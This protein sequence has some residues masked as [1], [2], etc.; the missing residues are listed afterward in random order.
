MIQRHFIIFIHLFIFHLIQWHLTRQGK[1]SAKFAVIFQV[2]WEERESSV[3]T[4]SDPKHSISEQH[5]GSWPTGGQ[6]DPGHLW[7]DFSLS[8]R[9]PEMQ[10]L[11]PEHTQ[12]VYKQ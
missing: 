9:T 3:I 12:A 11:C 8:R 6:S 5:L 7:G 4:D 2:F 10:E 1:S